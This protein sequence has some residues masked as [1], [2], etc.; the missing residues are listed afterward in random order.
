MT[1]QDAVSKFVKEIGKNP[2][3][4]Y[5]YSSMYV[6]GLTN[7]SGAYDNQIYVNKKTKEVGAFQPP[8]IPPKEYRE[9]K[10]IDLPIQHSD[11]LEHYGVLGMKWGVRR[12]PEE[13]GHRTSSSSK[14]KKR[15]DIE[16]AKRNAERAKEKLEKKRLKKERTEALK[17][18][19]AEK[20]RRDI[21]NDP[22]KLYKYRREF[23]QDEINA[24]L[25]QFEWE[26]KLQDFSTA[27]LETGRK[28]TQA[29]L[30]ILTAT[31]ASY[32][33]LARVV[34]TFS[35]D[36][37]LPYLEKAVKKEDDKKK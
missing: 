22:T 30:G 14:N 11:S 3:Y 29:A 13:L 31:L 16:K 21:L 32:D 9:G 7:N 34:N 35:S 28:K 24:A 26:R 36:V 20:R 1:V 25:K 27:K 8:M 10:K 37:K 15:S 18:A 17:K 4:C 23:S 5:E 33:Q 12:T 19:A 6:F 2:A